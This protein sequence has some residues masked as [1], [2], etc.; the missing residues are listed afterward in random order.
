MFLL[1]ITGRPAKTI[2]CNFWTLAILCTDLVR[3]KK[4]RY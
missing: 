3:T 2:A 1:F 4:N